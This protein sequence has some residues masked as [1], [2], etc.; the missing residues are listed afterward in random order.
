MKI[1]VLNGSPKGDLS[2]TMQ[3]I[4]Y[5]QKKFSQHELK[6]INIAERIGQIEKDKK[7]FDDI[8]NE[9]KSSDGVIWGF[10]LYFF[11]V[12][13]QYKRFIE[14]IFER[15]VEA[16][17]K[18][19]YTSILATSVKL[20]D[21][22]AINYMNSI[23]DDLNMNYVDYFSAHMDDLEKESERKNLLQFAQNYFDAIENR[24]VTFKNYSSINYSPIQYNSETNS[25]K[26]DV[27]SKKMVI[28]TDSLEDSNLKNMIEQFRNSFSSNIELISLKDIDIKGGCLGC[29]RCGYDFTCA[30]TG[31]DGFIDFY[32]SKMKTADIIIFAGT[33]KDR[34]LSSIWK[35]YFDRSFFNAHTPSLSGKQLGFIISGPLR[36]IPNLMEM[37]EGYAQWQMSNIVGFVTDEQK[38]SKEIDEQLYSL[39]LNVTHFS[40][41]DYHKPY[42]F[43]GTGFWKI[44]RDEIW[45]NL[46]FPFIADYKAYRELNIYDFPQKNYKSRIKN[47]ILILMVKIP[48]I[49]KETYANRLKP[50]IIAS[51]KKI[52]EDPNL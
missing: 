35:R 10:P 43:L 42:T 14:L 16:A 47:L 39:A 45:G 44:A 4:K 15:N 52:V 40:I 5:I 19:I 17:F 12:S 37:L 50:N 6:I 25:G 13:S 20:L 9:I 23:C 32:N 1:I 49:R 38:T 27:L 33:I 30:Y 2:A 8:I 24:R 18:G 34:Y 3:Y 51:L 29:I 48:A 11:L 36:Q 46:R 28:V 26:I 21:H 7:V 41:M 22:T 31:K